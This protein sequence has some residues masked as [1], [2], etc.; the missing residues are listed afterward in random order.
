MTVNGRSVTL[1]EM[2]KNYGARQKNMNK[3]GPILSAAKCR[4]MILVSRN[5]RYM[6]I[7]TGDGGSSGR[8]AKYNKCYTY[9]H[10][11]EHEHLFITCR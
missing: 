6:R 3:D 8:D 2:K 4:P 7:L 10:Y 9:V 5:I 1:A 11:F